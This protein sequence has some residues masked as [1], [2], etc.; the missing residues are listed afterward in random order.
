[1]LMKLKYLVMCNL[2]YRRCWATHTVVF[3]CRY[4]ICFF[5]IAVSFLVFTLWCSKSGSIDTL[6]HSV[7]C[8]SFV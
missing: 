4:V 6:W 1:M 3:S 5:V 2:F 8:S 7:A